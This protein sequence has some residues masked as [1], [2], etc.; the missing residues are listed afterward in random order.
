MRE[1]HLFAGRGGGILGGLLLGHRCVGAVD[2]NPHARDVLAARQRDG[3]LPSFPILGNVRPVECLGGVHVDFDPADWI[4]RVDVVCGGFP[5]QPYSFAGR[6]L[7]AEDE[8]DGWPDVA[9]TLDVIRPPFGF[10]ENVPGLLSGPRFGE[11]LADLAAL[12]YDVRWCV[13]GADD[14]GAP[15]RRD[16]LWMLA[17]RR[18]ANLDRPRQ[19]GA[20]GAGDE[21]ERAS[22]VCSAAY[23]DGEG[24]A[25]GDGDGYQGGPLAR[26]SG[27]DGEGA[28]SDVGGVDHGMAPGMD[29]DGWW[30]IERGLPRVVDQATG[31]PDRL[32][33]LGNGQVPLAAAVAWVYLGGP[34][35]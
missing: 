8:R 32:A 15:H 7:G 31:R 17:V 2:I 6:M 24:L 11:I 18:D 21:W 23:A 28:Q 9:R 16:R 19:H 13:F 35:T 34:V 1:L 30:A 12:G 3:L 14:V 27:I 10:F 20:Q 26:T 5:C 25:V 33:G 4:G 29:G 22:D